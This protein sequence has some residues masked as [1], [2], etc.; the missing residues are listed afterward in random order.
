MA[1][2]D[3]EGG[4]N[5][6]SIVV[7][8]HYSRPEKDLR[9]TLV[10]LP[11]GD[12]VVYGIGYAK[13]L[14]QC[15]CQGTVGFTAKAGV[16]TDLGHSLITPAWEPSPYPELAEESD[17]GRVARMDFGLFAATIR[18]VEEGDFVPSQ[19]AGATIVPAEYRAIGPWVD[20]RRIHAN[21]LGAVPGVLEYRDG[22]AYDPVAD[23]LLRLPVPAAQ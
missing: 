22:V 19:L 11:P 13:Y 17:L 6:Y 8:R 15:H 4:S 14:Y 12:Y 2:P 7:P 20:T 21:R 3:W 1:S 23:Q 5:F 18:P 9:V 10:E 16:V